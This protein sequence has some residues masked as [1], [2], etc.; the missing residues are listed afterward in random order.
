MRKLVGFIS[1]LHSV[2]GQPKLRTVALATSMVAGLGLVAPYLSNPAS[3]G[4]KVAKPAEE[5]VLAEIDEEISPGIFR[6]DHIVAGW[7]TEERQN[8]LDCNK[9]YWCLHF[10]VLDSANCSSKLKVDYSMWS[11]GDDLVATRSIFVSS[12]NIDDVFELGVEPGL[13]FESF[14]IDNV[15]CVVESSAPEII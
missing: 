9:F 12:R 7:V 1:K 3:F 8:A 10:Q 13:N 6:F 15:T 5:H 2:G 4:L 14:T 11:K